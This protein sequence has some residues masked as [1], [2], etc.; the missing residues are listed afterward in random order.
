M[1]LEKLQVK[2]ETQLRHQ[3]VEDSSLS[4]DIRNSH[5]WLLGIKREMRGLVVV[6]NR[7]YKTLKKR[8]TEGVAEFLLRQRRLD[9]SGHLPCTADM[10]HT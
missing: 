3:K 8:D 4:Q 2:S 1:F 9:S 5:N 6:P 10:I 7:K